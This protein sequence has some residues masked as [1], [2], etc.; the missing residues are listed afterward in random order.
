[1]DVPKGV[2]ADPILR[3]APVDW[4]LAN[5]TDLGESPAALHLGLQPLDSGDSTL[6]VRFTSPSLSSPARHHFPRKCSD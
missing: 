4:I 5:M 2:R 3:G 1:M 6:I